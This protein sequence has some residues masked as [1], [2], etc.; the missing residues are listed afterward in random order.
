[1]QYYRFCRLLSSIFIAFLLINIAG[2]T[3]TSDSSSTTDKGTATKTES[4]KSKPKPAV[5]T[6]KFSA[7]SAY[8]FIQKQVDFGPRTPG[9]AEHKACA[10]W[11][12]KTMKQYADEVNV[13]TAEVIVYTGA[14][15]PMYNIISSFN[16][17]ADYRVLLCAH[18]DTRHIAD[19]DSDPARTKE[20]IIGAND[21][22]SGVGV[23]MEI[24]RMLKNTPI[25]MGVD[26]IFFD[27]EDYGDSDTDDSYCLGSQYWGNNLHKVGY[28]AKYGILLDMVGA[29]DATFLREQISDLFASN[30][31][32]KVWSTAESLGY[33]SY[34]KQE[35]T[36]TP[37]T[38]D[39]LYVN[40]RA[41]IPTIDIIHYTPQGSFG[42]FWHTHKDD[43]KV[44]DKGALKAVG[45]TVATVLYKENNRLPKK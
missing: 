36:R 1:M 11:L 44:I 25:D 32:D 7:D 42:H 12:E 19:H 22:G 35:R 40:Q 31:V 18:W 26:I 10:E 8:Q 29:A 28:T 4:S 20:P 41:G 6:P 9:T 13:Q 21:G 14:K 5:Q 37:I 15:K 24:A 3:N 17:A 43:M 30:I 33:G 45:Q 39:H 2:C 16:P 34:F 23:L 38:D 27:V